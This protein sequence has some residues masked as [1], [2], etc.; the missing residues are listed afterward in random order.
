LLASIFRRPDDEGRLDLARRVGADEALVLD[1]A[2][3]NDYVAELTS[4]IGME[5][6]IEMAGTPEAVQLI[7]HRLPLADALDGFAALR[8]REAVKVMYDPRF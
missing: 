3:A 8:R 5:P 4:G 1:R 2:G 6:V 7:T